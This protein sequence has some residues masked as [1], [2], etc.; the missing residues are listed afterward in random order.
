MP[1]SENLSGHKGP[2]HIGLRGAARSFSASVQ[3]NLLP[4]KPNA[5]RSASRLLSGASPRRQHRRR[6]VLSQRRQSRVRASGKISARPRLLRRRRDPSKLRPRRRRRTRS[7]PRP[8]SSPRSRSAS[9]ISPP[10]F[11]CGSFSSACCSRSSCSCCCGG[12][13]PIST[14]VSGSG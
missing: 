5:D 11:S 3:R 14:N 6:Y 8:A 10:N 12:S 7:L 13:G 1:R 9:P 2:S 4:G